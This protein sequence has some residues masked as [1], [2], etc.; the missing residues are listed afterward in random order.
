MKHSPL[1]KRIRF[2]DLKCQFIT[3]EGN[4]NISNLYYITFISNINK[5]ITKKNNLY[6]LK[7]KL[8]ISIQFKL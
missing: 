6:N 7:F 5:N 2:L 8:N 4:L 1:K 3:T